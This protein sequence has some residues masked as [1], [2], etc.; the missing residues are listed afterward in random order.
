[1]I[2]PSQDTLLGQVRQEFDRLN[3]ANAELK[4]KN[5]VLNGQIAHHKVEAQTL[6]SQLQAPGA[7][8]VQGP[9][10]LYIDD[11]IARRLAACESGRRNLQLV[12]HNHDMPDNR[13]IINAR[14][15]QLYIQ[16][17][18]VANW[19]WVFHRMHDYAR[20][21]NMQRR[22]EEVTQRANRGNYHFRGGRDVSLSDCQ[23]MSDI[24]HELSPRAIAGRRRRRGGIH[25]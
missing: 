4:Q 16:A 23:I 25:V 20:N 6:R 17:H 3:A 7:A 19:N 24:L 22:W 21:M 15:L 10:Q 11:K 5:A 1:M 18:G 12:I 2:T 13:M 14:N 9:P 8:V